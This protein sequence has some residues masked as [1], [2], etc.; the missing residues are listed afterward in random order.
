MFVDVCCCGWLV[1][2]SG[3]LLT[4]FDCGLVWWLF[5][6]LWVACGGFWFAAD[7]IW[8]WVIVVMGV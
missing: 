6:S 5:D 3:F 4:C 7:L 1:V 8:L 2:V